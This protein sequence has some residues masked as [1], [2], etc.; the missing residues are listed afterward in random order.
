MVKYGHK[1]FI[2]IHNHC[3]KYKFGKVACIQWPAGVSFLCCQVL[4]T[5]ELRKVDPLYYN[6]N[7]NYYNYYNYNYNYNY[8][9]SNYNNYNYNYNRV[10]PPSLIQ[11]SAILDNKESLLLQVTGCRLLYQIYI[12]NNGYESGWRFCDRT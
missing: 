1:I 6:Y 8:N 2:R 11:L 3:L 4:P 5:V 10:G 9:Y 7:Y 12:L